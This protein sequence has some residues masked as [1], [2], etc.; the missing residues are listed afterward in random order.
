MALTLNQTLLRLTAANYYGVPPLTGSVSL[1]QGTGIVN[2]PNPI[3]GAGTIALA[4]PVAV[5]NGG[6][7]LT[8]GTSGGVLYFSGAGVI[9]SSP[10]LT[11]NQLLV[12]AGAGN[13]PVGLGTLGTTS[14]VLH[15]NAAGLPTFGA[16]SLTADVTGVLPVANGG[17]GVSTAFTT[18][19][20]IFAGAAGVYSQ[21]ANFFW[22]NTTVG[23]KIG[24]V[25]RQMTPSFLVVR[26]TAG[27]QIEFGHSNAGGYGSSLGAT[28]SNGLPFLTFFCESGTAADTYRTRGILGNIMQANTSGDLI[29]GQATTANADNQTLTERMRLTSAG[30]LGI[31]TAGPTSLLTVNGTME[32]KAGSGGVLKFADGT[33]QASAAVGGG[34]VTGTGTATNVAFWSAGSTISSDNAL[35]WDN[36]NKRLG[37]GLTTPG[38]SLHVLGTGTPGGNWGVVGVVYPFSK[39]DTT[40]RNVAAWTSNDGAGANFKLLLTATGHAATAASRLFAFQTGTESVANDGILALQHLGGRVAIGN[41]LPATTL[42]VTG[43]ITLKDTLVL[44]G[45]TSGYWA[46]K[47]AATSSSVTLTL[48]AGDSTGT[49]YLRSNGAGVLSWGTPAGAGTVTT[50]GALSAGMVTFIDPS[51]ATVLTGEGNLFYDNLNNR[52]GILTSAPI[53]PLHIG[54][55]TNAPVL[56]SQILVDVASAAYVTVKDTADSTEVAFG[57]DILG[58]YVGTPGANSLRILTNNTLAATVNTSQQIITAGAVGVGMTPTRSLD[59]VNTGYGRM[60]VQDYGGEVFN[61]MA[62]GATPDTVGVDQTPFFAAALAAAAAKITATAGVSANAQAGPTVYVPP[63]VYRFTGGAPA[64]PTTRLDIPDGVSLV[65]GMGADSHSGGYPTLE[66]VDGAGTTAGI[67]FCTVGA[68]SKIMGFTI[69]YPNQVNTD[70]PTAYPFAIAIGPG[71]TAKNIFLYNAYQGIDA[72]YSVHGYGNTSSFQIEGISGQPLLTGIN[73]DICADYASIRNVHFWEYTHFH[74]AWQLANATI[75]IQIGRCDGLQMHDIEIWNYQTGIKLY[76]GTGVI[77]GT[78]Y[79]MWSNI[80]LES[81]VTGIDVYAT[82]NS[83]PIVIHGL[84]SGASGN[85][86]RGNATGGVVTGYGQLSISGMTVYGGATPVSWANDGNLLITN[87]VFNYWV[88]GYAVDV[89]KG[90]VIVNG[91]LFSDGIAYAGLG[92]PATKFRAQA[93][94]DRAIF[95]NNILPAGTTSFLNALFVN[96]NNLT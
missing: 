49:Q 91:N 70:P 62:Y 82:N 71:A 11:S 33:S 43:N 31:G 22:D 45:A 8:T 76:S 51:G 94:C 14:T 63:G 79:G 32:I 69:N 83:T 41:I 28:T 68:G 59:V 30:L 92:A 86:I 78:C 18:G 36:A 24:N 38:T 58:G 5:A 2:T 39:T 75:A 19:S 13:P 73:V 23:L 96:A 50:N 93:T 6:T 89:S 4:V 60:K 26:G 66:V 16:V 74:Q 44:S 15:G 55:Q 53:A 37:I 81:I 10:A 80:Q 35:Y 47:A 3:T 9:A 77:P 21:N 25:T 84:S 1:S 46:L 27:S 87:S 90:R 40:I 52:L 64:T 85:T 42:D 29:F 95:T 54:A 56:T 88:S 20:V 57:A 12:G 7:G 72:G 17:S 67:P 61:V 65:G 48:P 34:T